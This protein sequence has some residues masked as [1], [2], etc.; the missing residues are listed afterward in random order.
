VLGAC[1]ER[2]DHRFTGADIALQ[3]NLLSDYQV[4][5]GRFQ[6]LIDKHRLMRWYD[7]ALEAAKNDHREEMDRITSDGTETGLGTDALELAEKQIAEGEQRK[8]DSSW[9][10]N[11]HNSRS[12]SNGHARSTRAPA[13][14]H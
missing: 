6:E 1:T 5:D 11:S 9:K 10:S 13:I 12:T 8:V 7:T 3:E 4:E 14:Q 2:L